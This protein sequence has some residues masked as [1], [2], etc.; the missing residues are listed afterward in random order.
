MITWLTS[1]KQK[2]HAP[3][4]AVLGMIVLALLVYTYTQF[5]STALPPTLNV[6]GVWRMDNPKGTCHQGRWTIEIQPESMTVRDPNEAARTSPCTIVVAPNEP[7]MVFFK[8]NLGW[9]KGVRMAVFLPK[10][11]GSVIMNLSQDELDPGCQH[12]V[13][14]E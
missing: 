14:K 11:D 3:I 5:R 2:Y 6:F 4:A 7:A 10:R 9:G 8:E 1:L 13:L 12:P